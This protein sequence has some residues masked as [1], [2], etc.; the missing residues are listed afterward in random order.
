MNETEIILRTTKRISLV[1]INWMLE[2]FLSGF[3]VHLLFIF[4]NDGD[5]LLL[6]FFDF[7]KSILI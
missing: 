4:S 6:P 2:I 3:T 7:M 5:A 1:P